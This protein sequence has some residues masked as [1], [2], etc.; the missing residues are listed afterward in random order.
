MKPLSA[1][2]ALAKAANLCAKGEHCAADIREKLFQWGFDGDADSII[3]KLVQQDFINEVRYTHAYIH[4][5]YCFAKWGRVKIEQGLRLKQISS[6]TIH[7]QMEEVIDKEVYTQNLRDLLQQKRK[8]LQG[9]DNFQIKTKLVRFA[10]QR[11]FTYEEVFCN[12]DD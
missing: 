9:N 12:I 1:T 3:S 8:T 10:L 2:E 7:Q 4:D 5:K 6:A 11:G